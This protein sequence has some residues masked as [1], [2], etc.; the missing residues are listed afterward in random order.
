[1]RIA[2]LH[3]LARPVPL[4][5][6]VCASA[7]ALSWLAF[8]RGPAVELP[9]ATV[10]RGR[11]ED[12]VRA[13]GSLQPFATQGIRSKVRGTLLRV[14]EDGARVEKGGLLLEI[15]ALPFQEQLA[16]QEALLARI[17][18]EQMKDRQALAKDLRTAQGQVRQ[19]AERLE[20]EQLK[21]KDLEDG[22]EES[23]R[24][25][26]QVKLENARTL[27]RSMTDELTLMSSLA[28]EARF[29]KALLEQKRLDLQE[30]KIKV[31][32]ARLA[33]E[34][35]L[36][37]DVVAVTEQR[38]KIHDAKN[39]L[40]AAQDK[41]ATVERSMQ[42]NEAAFAKRLK[43]AE[44]RRA[45]LQ[46]NIDQ[47]KVLAPAPGYVL[48]GSRRGVKYGPGLSVGGRE[49]MKFSDLSRVK[50]VVF[51]D[52]GRV[53]M[54][55]PGHAATVRASVLAGQGRGSAPAMPGKVTAVAEH[56][57]DEFEEYME[58]TRDLIGRADRQVFKVDIELETDPASARPGQMVEAEIVVRAMDGV[59]LVPRTA[60]FTHPAGGRC[61]W[62]LGAF[63]AERAAIQVLAENATTA[64]VTGLKEGDRVRLTA[65]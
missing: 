51:V 46:E 28:K 16:E 18:A 9:F 2:L 44:D 40:R 35:L 60:L 25:D 57:Q 47:S 63:A 37:A 11:F 62:R 36:R 52:E 32:A 15:D 53:G 4:A 13:R 65:P 23:E 39:G 43:D 10:K 24:L 3:R 8:G 31:E 56:G 7:L 41:A 42:R 50:A 49:I 12:V 1:M 54:L 20:L 19:T 64:A 6:A 33:L 59:L 61:V 30:Q 22:P 29:S 21:L 48:I 5:A 38:Q 34:K 17:Y 58:E 14:A 45:E 55:A 27:H 26:A